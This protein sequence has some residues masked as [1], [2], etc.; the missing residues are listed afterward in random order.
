[1]QEFRRGEKHSEK[2]SRL[3]KGA[4]AKVR[5][6]LLARRNCL[7]VHQAHTRYV[8]IS[9]HWMRGLSDGFRFAPD[10]SASSQRAMFR[11]VPPWAHLRR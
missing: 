5:A 7:V 9:P 10:F 3:R 1:M 2:Q 8:L 11:F 6:V 4:A